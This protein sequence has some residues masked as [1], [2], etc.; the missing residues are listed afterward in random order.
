MTPDHEVHS[1]WLRDLASDTHQ[2][3]HVRSASAAGAAALDELATLRA[4]CDRLR[5]DDDELLYQVGT[6]FPGESR[7]E[8][9]KRYLRTHEDHC[10][11]GGPARVALTPSPEETNG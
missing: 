2:S 7:H 1:A 3:V 8:T 10:G 4:E 9:A 6:K 5:A 11:K